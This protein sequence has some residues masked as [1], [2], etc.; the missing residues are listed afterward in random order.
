MILFILIINNILAIFKSGIN[1]FERILIILKINSILIIFIISRI[2][3]LYRH[4]V[5]RYSINST[6]LKVHLSRL[7][8]CIVCYNSRIYFLDSKYISKNILKASKHNLGEI[9]IKQV[10]FIHDPHIYILHRVET[11]IIH[12]RCIVEI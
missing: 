4:K 7:I 12:I 3:N 1:I 2:L 10:I 11:D 5:C 9:H 6:Q 8:I